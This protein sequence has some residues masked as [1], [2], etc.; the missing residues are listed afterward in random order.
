MACGSCGARAKVVQLIP[1]S[2]SKNN[3]YWIDLCEGYKIM[4][5]N[6]TYYLENDGELYLSSL[7]S[8]KVWAKENCNY[9]L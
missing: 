6:E 2:Y 5:K 1:N 3:W 8:L 7:P 4:Y 9:D